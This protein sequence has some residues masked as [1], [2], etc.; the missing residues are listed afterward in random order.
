MCITR[1][2]VDAPQR[3]NDI[4]S[5]YYVYQCLLHDCIWHACKQAENSPFNASVIWLRSPT[6]YSKDT[7]INRI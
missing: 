2:H 5:R 4:Q 3:D 7:V 6:G 1:M